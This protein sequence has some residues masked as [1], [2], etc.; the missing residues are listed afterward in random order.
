VTERQLSNRLPSGSVHPADDKIGR[1]TAVPPAP[2]LTASAD[3]LSFLNQMEQGKPTTQIGK[4]L[5]VCRR[6]GIDV[7]FHLLA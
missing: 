5:E 7:V 3:S 6:Y 2:N 4:V 1:A